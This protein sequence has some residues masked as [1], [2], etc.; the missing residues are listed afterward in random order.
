MTNDL[1]EEDKNRLLTY[2]D[3]PLSGNNVQDFYD[4][5]KRMEELRDFGKFYFFIG[6]K[7]LDEPLNEIEYENASYNSDFFLWLILNPD[8]CKLVSEG[9]KKEGK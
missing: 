2:L 3:G 4:I 7:F 1:T 9:L 5:V 6:N 8:N